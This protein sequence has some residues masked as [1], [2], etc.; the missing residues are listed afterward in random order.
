MINR[1]YSDL[2]SHYNINDDL[3]EG[4]GPGFLDMNWALTLDMVTVI[5]D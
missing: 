4:F 5:P 2:Q 3:V 1:P